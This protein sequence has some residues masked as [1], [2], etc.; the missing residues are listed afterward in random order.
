M[1]ENIITAVKTFF[2]E[3]KSSSIREASKELGLCTWIV[4]HKIY[5]ESIQAWTSAMPECCSRGMASFGFQI[6]DS[7]PGRVV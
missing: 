7:I 2:E 1:N 5:M 4:Q 3:K 6:L